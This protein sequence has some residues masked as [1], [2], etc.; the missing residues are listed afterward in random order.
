MVRK[1]H[2]E[3]K[4]FMLGILYW[5]SCHRKHIEVKCE[6]DQNEV[7][8]VEHGQAI[9]TSLPENFQSWGWPFGSRICHF[10]IQNW[11]IFSGSHLSQCSTPYISPW[12]QAP[13]PRS[14]RVPSATCAPVQAHPQPHGPWDIPFHL[15]SSRKNHHERPPFF[16]RH[17]DMQREVKKL[18]NQIQLLSVKALET[19]PL[20]NTLCKQRHA[21]LPVFLLSWMFPHPSKVPL[22]STGHQS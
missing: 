5:G 8:G 7:D 6:V 21:T 3:M 4:D 14:F 19:S 9:Q 15:N 11:L 20:V 12:P 1:G 2:I 22:S 17:S 10:N 13:P 16:V 18:T